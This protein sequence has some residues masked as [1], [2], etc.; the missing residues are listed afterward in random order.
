LGIAALE[1]K[2]VQRAVTGVLNAI[3]E[4]DFLGF[5]YGF[6]TGRRPHEALDA[7]AAG[8]RF[9]KVSWVLDADIRGY[10]D[11]INHEWLLRFLEHRIGDKRVLRLVKKWL[12]AG[13]VESGK[14]TGSEEGTP[15]G[16]SLSPLL[17][18]IYLHY[19]LD[20]WAH[21]WR[22]C[23]ARGDV[24][25]VRWADDFVLGFEDR[26]DARRFLAE[27]QS[28]LRKFSLELHP[29]KTRL[30][31][32]GRFARRDSRR[33][34]GQRKPETFN[35]LGFTHAC[36]VTLAGKFMVLRTTIRK[37]FIAKIRHIGIELRKRRHLSIMQQ[38]IWLRSV[39]QGYFNYHA[40]PG[41]GKRLSAFRGQVARKWYRSLR[42]RSQRSRLD[43]TKMTRI[44]AKWL[45]PVRILHPWPEERFLATTRGRSPVR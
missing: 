44:V 9:K 7:L 18:N 12:R 6:G 17:A 39:V 38:G 21:Q 22:R 26:E 23:S 34:D 3:Y 13:V 45:P 8:I 20:L 15:Q 4:V 37:R 35:F 40:I 29:E 19:V 31:R 41:N 42:R 1:D 28:R 5:S 24:I 11:A 33:L 14:W 2:I 16:A 27:L 25:I 10:F 43:W 36:S 32:F 30:I